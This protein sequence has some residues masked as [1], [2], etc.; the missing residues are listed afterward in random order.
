MFFI[1]AMLMACLVEARP[2]VSLY[3]ESYEDPFLSVISGVLVIATV[4]VLVI[5]CGDF[6]DL[7][8]MTRSNTNEGVE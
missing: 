3:H 6:V 8:S 2:A 1:L 5:F 7:C 4:V